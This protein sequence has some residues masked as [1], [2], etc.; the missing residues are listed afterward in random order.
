MKSLVE[1]ASKIKLKNESELVVF[2]PSSIY[3][4]KADFS[5]IKIISGALLENI[6]FAEEHVTNGF[7]AHEIVTLGNVNFLRIDK[8]ASVLSNLDGLEST[9][10]LF[11]I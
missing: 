10:N 8:F 3:V 4:D 1:I 2:E 5:K 6:V 11:Y 7:G 9:E